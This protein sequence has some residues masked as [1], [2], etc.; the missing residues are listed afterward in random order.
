MKLLTKAANAIRSL[1]RKKGDAPYVYDV[2]CPTHGPTRWN[3]ETICE[4]CHTLCV[5][6][7]PKQFCKGCRRRLEQT[8][9]VVCPACYAERKSRRG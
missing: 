5:I 9:K 6:N 2:D 4:A 1:F 8:A 7:N 3:G